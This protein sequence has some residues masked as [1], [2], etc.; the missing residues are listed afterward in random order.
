MSLIQ[1][2]W[3]GLVQG[4]TEFLPVSSSGHLA[5][6]QALLG[7]Q[8]GL[9]FDILL[10]LGTLVAVLVVYW[11]QVVRLVQAA[12]SLVWPASWPAE[13][14]AG[15]QRNL[16]LLAGLIIGSVPA[17]LA[18]LFLEKQVEGLFT[19][20]R[21]VGILFWVTA[22]FLIMADLKARHAAV[23][24]PERVPTPGQALVVGIGQALALPPGI[25]RSGTTVFF[26][27]LAGLP[28][29]QA[30]D[31][32]FLLSIPVIAGAGVLSIPDLIRSG[33]GGATPWGTYLAGF[34][35]AALAGYAAIRLLL[36]LIRRARLT[37]FSAYL[38]ALGALILLGW[39]K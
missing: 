28:R 24:E 38:F 20:L 35:M 19:E 8:P 12:V 30:A 23:D 7:V 5:V 9:A 21:V 18:G 14:R 33:T 31:F 10:H 17:A 26:A 11:S 15:R 32:S 13:D 29:E 4:L 27:L 6:V 39:L 16:R 22:L 25:S 34:G 36:S 2:L 37:V 3:L 1:A